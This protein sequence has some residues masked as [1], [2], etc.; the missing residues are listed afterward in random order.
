MTPDRTWDPKR[1]QR[2]TRGFAA[3]M[4]ALNGFIVLGFGAVVVPAAGLPAPADAWLT[5]VAIA[6][7]IA[8][9][10]AVVGLVRARTWARSTV[11]YVA[12]GG[13]GA[14]TFAMLLITRA[15]EPI[16]G[17]ADQTTIGF[18]VWMIGSWLVAARFT[19]MAY[20][21]PRQPARRIHLAAPRVALPTTGRITEAPARPALLAA[22]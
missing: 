9:L 16:L 3:F 5:G 20:R 1:F 11:L 14:M 12:A 15:G 10:V 7:G 4:T 13:I 22:A 21:D 6:A 2:G 8:Q 19:Y 18:L 17:A